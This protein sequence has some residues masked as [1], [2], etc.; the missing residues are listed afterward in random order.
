MYRLILVF[1][2]FCWFAGPVKAIDAT[3]GH[4]VYFLPDPLY[5]SR[6]N[7]YIEL[8]WQV[9]PATL[10]YKTNEEKQIVGHFQTD[11]LITND[12]GKIIKEDHYVF[13]TLPCNNVSE[14]GLLNILELKRYFLLAGKMNIRLK[15]TDVNDT[16][17]KYFYVDTLTV[18]T[19]PSNPF[20][21]DITLADTIYSSSVR[22]PFRKHGMQVI[23][24][25][26]PFV[27]DYKRSMSY[28][29]ELYYPT[30]IKRSLYPLTTTVSISKK[31]NSSLVPG[32]EKI[33]SI[34]N[35]I[36]KYIQSLQSTAANSFRYAIST[37]NS[38]I[39]Y[40]KLREYKT[41]L[42]NIDPS[43]KVNFEN[44][45]NTTPN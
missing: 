9:N 26:Q 19:A 1:I 5:T 28:F 3:V 44:I 12:T 38:K 20:F 43:I 13:N 33:D 36:L 6:L 8:Y 40:F 29:T 17:N 21:G 31:E 42:L 10:R 35:E 4:S 24:L 34:S 23:P 2:I 45:I 15:L 39:L 22:T 41:E 37:E 7:P 18:A 16:S 25:C 14:L 27:D 30:L 11:V 32:F